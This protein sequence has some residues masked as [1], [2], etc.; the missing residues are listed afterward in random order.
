MRATLK[1]LEQAQASMG[2]AGIY[3]PLICDGRAEL[4]PINSRWAGGTRASGTPK[5]GQKVLNLFVAR[6]VIAEIG[7]VSVPAKSGRNEPGHEHSSWPIGHLCLPAPD[8]GPRMKPQRWNMGAASDRPNQRIDSGIQAIGEIGRRI[9]GLNAC[10]ARHDQPRIS[11]NGT[12]TAAASRKLLVL[13]SEPI[14][15]MI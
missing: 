1:I 12:P 8:V 7:Q 13:Q 14:K 15:A 11:L 4:P 10:A 2:R 9:I 6:S 3:L 5:P